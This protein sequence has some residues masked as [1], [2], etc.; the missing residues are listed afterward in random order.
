VFCELKCVLL[1]NTLY[2]DFVGKNTWTAAV[3]YELF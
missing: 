1:M 3:Q 2:C